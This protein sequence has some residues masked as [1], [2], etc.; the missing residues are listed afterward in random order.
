MSDDDPKSV[1]FSIFEDSKQSSDRQI[2]KRWAGEP[3]VSLKTALHFI[4]TTKTN[5]GLR[6]DVRLERRKYTTGETVSQL[7]MDTTLT[8]HSPHDTLPDW[9]YTLH[10]WPTEEM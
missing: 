5:T 4:R 1:E 3:L 7:D 10:P 9:N 2:T 6:L 8:A